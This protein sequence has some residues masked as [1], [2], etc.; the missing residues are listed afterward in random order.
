[1]EARREAFRA[2]KVECYAFERRR[3]AVAWFF[4]PSGPAPLESGLGSMQSVRGR[5]LL[6]DLDRDAARGEA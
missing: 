4:G 2:A 5:D 1:M 3:A 6:G